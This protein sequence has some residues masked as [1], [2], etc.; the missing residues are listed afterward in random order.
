MSQRL[1]LQLMVGTVETFESTDYMVP[2]YLEPFPEKGYLVATDRVEKAIHLFA[3][4]GKHLGKAG[5]K[6]RGPG[7]FMGAIMLHAS[8]DNYLYTYDSALRRIT[9]FKLNQNGISYVDTYS[10]SQ[11]SLTWLRNIYVTKWGNFGVFRSLVDASTGEEEF[12]LY[13]LDDEFNSTELI[14]TMPGNEKMPLSEMQYIDHMAGENT[15]WDLDGEWFYHISS[16]NMAINKYNL[17]TGESETKT[18]FELVKREITDETRKQLMEYSFSMAKRFPTVKEAMEKVEFLPIFEEFAVHNNTIY[19]LIFDVSR[20][21]RTEI[22]RI[23]QETKEI[24][25]LEIPLALRKIQGGNGLIYGI[26]LED[27]AY[28]SIKKIALSD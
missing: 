25:Y 9:R 19:L 15:F 10:P 24:Q 21:E 13:K 27:G 18:Y 2:Y 7:E 23:N 20:S 6:G 22:I 17:R 3:E 12:Y 5:G 28:A 16:H 8:W 4:S 11:K 1:V 26:E 14:L